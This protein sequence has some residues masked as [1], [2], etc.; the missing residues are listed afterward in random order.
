[1]AVMALT[2]LS[3]PLAVAA[4]IAVLAGY[5]AI[6]IHQRDAARARA[7]ALGE[8]LDQCA[9]ETDAL[10]R[11]IAERNA[12]VARMQS[13]QAQVAAAERSRETAAAAR[14]EAALK[15]ELAQAKAIENAPVA[16]G[17]EGAIEW[18]NG[19]GPELGQW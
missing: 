12:A 8:R 15:H 18:G 2:Y 11:A 19:E 3:K 14:A 16:S 17:C 10:R 1:M 6:L 7:A 9:A 5:R 13:A 4:L